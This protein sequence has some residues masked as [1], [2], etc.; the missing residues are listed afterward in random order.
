MFFFF[1]TCDFEKV[2]LFKNLKIKRNLDF[3]LRVHGG[4]SWVAQNQN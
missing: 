1:N 4:Y 2:V 3:Y